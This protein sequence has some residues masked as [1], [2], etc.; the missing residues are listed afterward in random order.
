MKANTQ[1][2]INIGFIGY[3][4][5]HK[6][7]HIFEE[8]ANKY[9]T[10]EKFQ[11][12]YIGAEKQSNPYINHLKFNPSSEDY[13]RSVENLKNK[14]LDYILHW[15]SC[16]ETFSFTAHEA[17]AI[18]ALLLTHK[19]TG[20]VAELVIKHKFGIVFEDINELNN[21][22]DSDILLENINS[23]RKEKLNKL[24]DLKFSDITLPYLN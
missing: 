7:W 3:P 8:I 16:Y 14:G 24:V 20:N 22:L 23:F 18:G 5:N 10:N 13:L 9:K 12:T 11:F 19:N 21:Y 15:S 2:K 17:I 1:Q 6:G 4:V